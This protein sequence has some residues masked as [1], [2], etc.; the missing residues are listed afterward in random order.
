VLVAKNIALFIKLYRVSILVIFAN[1][2]PV[3]AQQWMIRAQVIGRAI[4]EMK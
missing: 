2:I 4:K 3:R 1:I